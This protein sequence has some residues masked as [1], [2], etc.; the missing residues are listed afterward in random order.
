M[1]LSGPT[2]IKDRFP[3][4]GLLVGL[5]S[6]LDHDVN[7][8]QL[9]PG[10]DDRD[11]PEPKGVNFRLYIAWTGDATDL[12]GTFDRNREGHAAMRRTV[13]SPDFDARG[14]LADRN[15]ASFEDDHQWKRDA[16]RNIEH[17]EA[18][19]CASEERH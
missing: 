10:R 18:L 4:E 16:A 5:A 1:R 3:G 8:S 17:G 13:L 7:P 19:P 14:V 2:T 6:A 15:L 12:S 11:R 9:S